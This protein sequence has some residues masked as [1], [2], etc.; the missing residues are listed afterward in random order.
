MCEVDF[1]KTLYG[2]EDCISLQAMD[3]GKK[4]IFDFVQGEVFQAT[5]TCTI[6]RKPAIE[7]SFSLKSLILSFVN[8]KFENAC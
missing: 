5:S 4:D 3:F 7:R 2:D 6:E 1:Q 8:P